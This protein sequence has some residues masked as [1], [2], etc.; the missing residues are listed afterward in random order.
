MIGTDCVDCSMAKQS[1]NLRPD[2]SFTELQQSG[3]VSPMKTAAARIVFRRGCAFEICPRDLRTN[4]HPYRHLSRHL[5][6]RAWTKSPVDHRMN[7]VCSAHP[8]EK[9]DSVSP[10]LAWMLQASQPGMPGSVDHDR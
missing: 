5:M 7:H 3:V 10:G 1:S 6:A 9:C 8:I 4:P 2:G